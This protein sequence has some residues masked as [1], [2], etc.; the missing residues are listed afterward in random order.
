[1]RRS[2][3][4][5]SLVLVVFLLLAAVAAPTAGAATEPEKEIIFDI[6]RTKADWIRK[7]KKFGPPIII[8]HLI[9]LG[10]IKL[11]KMWKVD[12]IINKYGHPPADLLK[13]WNEG[14]TMKRKAR[15]H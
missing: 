9:C 2:G 5:L 3:G 12:H 7:L 1:M 13:A 10:S 11:Y 14:K 6:P 8:S 4:L 15:A